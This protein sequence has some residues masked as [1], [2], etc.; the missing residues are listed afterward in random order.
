MIIFRKVKIRLF[1]TMHMSLMLNADDM[2]L[3]VVAVGFWCVMIM[4]SL[5]YEIL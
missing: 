1:T 2:M 5:R 3:E 4:T